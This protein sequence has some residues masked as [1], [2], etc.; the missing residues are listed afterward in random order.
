MVAG[1]ARGSGLDGGTVSITASVA[2]IRIGNVR[3]YK[4][5]S[6]GCRK[7]EIVRS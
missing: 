4:S 3:V 5:G 6:L 1:A 2:D 7:E